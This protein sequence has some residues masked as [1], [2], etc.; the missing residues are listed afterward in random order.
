MAVI[1]SI[2][3][4]IV[5]KLNTQVPGAGMINKGV[6]ATVSGEKFVLY[7]Q[8]GMYW[9]DRKALLLADLHLGKV[10][11]FRRAGIPVPSRANKHNLESLVE[12]IA[13]SGAQRVICLGD[14]FHSHYNGEWEE[15]GEVVR[16]FAEIRFELVLGN[17]DIMSRIQY[18]RKGV[19]VYDQL[20]LGPFLLT[21]HPQD[22]V[23]GEFYNLAGHVHPGVRLLGK[24]RQAMT[25]PC[26]YFG[27]R[28]GLLPAFG[29][30]TGVARI[31]P[32]KE[33]QVYVIA[34]DKV[35]TVN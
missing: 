33:D 10:S 14:L 25:L 4:I 7:P 23:A 24:G 31:H 35:V 28:Q 2:L 26:F 3:I 8:R 13:I 32:K 17:H 6:E 29:A 30:F 21:H 27:N 1:L 22:T 34:A 5:Q 16:N 11:H 18:E 19:T 12:L 20:R 9:P 15:F